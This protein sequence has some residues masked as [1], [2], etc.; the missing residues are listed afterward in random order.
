MQRRTSRVH[1]RVPVAPIDKFR[2]ANFRQDGDLPEQ[3][4]LPHPDGSSA[5]PA[6]KAP[7]TAIFFGRL[8]ASMLQIAAR[9]FSTVISC[10]SDRFGV[11]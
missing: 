2:S 5:S 10:R 3:I 7:V 11:P 1:S 9:S 4:L 8:R 6:F